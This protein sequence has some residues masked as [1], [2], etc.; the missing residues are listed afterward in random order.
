MPFANK[1]TKARRKLIFK[2]FD[3][4]KSTID[5][6]KG[7]RCESQKELD[8]NEEI[9]WKQFLYPIAK[10]NK[11]M[12]DLIVI[13]GKDLSWVARSIKARCENQTIS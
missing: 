7:L 2:L 4:E 3:E 6:N 12:Y 9:V 13:K 10:R 11:I 1:D 5:I 8:N